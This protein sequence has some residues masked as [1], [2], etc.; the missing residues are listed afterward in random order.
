LDLR[1]LQY[2]NLLGIYLSGVW[3][4]SLVTS[5]PIQPLFSGQILFSF[6]SASSDMAEILLAQKPHWP[7]DDDI[8]LEA[9][10]D[11]TACGQSDDCQFA[12]VFLPHRVALV[13][14][15]CR[16]LQHL[17]R[18]RTTISYVKIIIAYA[19]K[20]YLYYKGVRCCL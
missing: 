18:L 11:V 8:A 13:L 17:L 9:N 2:T 20:C 3:L 19:A 10:V 15:R 1:L 6:Y 14:V 16:R 12:Q 7:E 4:N 5:Y